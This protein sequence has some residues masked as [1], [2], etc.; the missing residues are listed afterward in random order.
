MV[1]QE[2]LDALANIS[3]PQRWKDPHPTY[4]LLRDQA[5]MLH[6]VDDDNWMLTRYDDCLQILRDPRWSSSPR[7]LRRQRPFEQQTMRER[8]GAEGVAIL[9]FMDPPDHTRLRKLVHRSFTPKAVDRWRVRIEEVVDDLLDQAVERGG[10]LELI[11]EFAYEVPVIV[12]C[13]LLGVPTSDH[14]LFG[15]WSSAAS[16][17]LDGDITPAEEQAGL[18]GAAG[19]IGYFNELIEERRALPGDD[20]LSAMIHATEDGDRLNED[21]L[22][23]MTLL[24]FIAGHETT[25]N[26]IGNGTLAL[27]RHRDQLERL[28]ADPT[29]VGSAVEEILRFDGPVHV[30]G[31]IPTEDLEVA[32]HVFEKGEQVVTLLA[33][34][35]RDPARFAEP[36]R[37]DIGRSDN[38]HLTFSMGIHHCLGASL[39]R[40][41]GQ[42]ALGRLVARFPDVELHTTDPEYREHFVLR[43]LRELRL[44]LGVG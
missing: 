7:H 8:S 6:N 38:Q 12:I 36:D 44:G 15:D 42:I 16:R 17:L 30:T 23:M 41:E 10:D 14:H 39:A 37:F 3:D 18:L 20:L 24:L 40:L 33:A 28:R 35:N 32:G 13:E 26:L 19:L 11:S 43:G 22:R 29:L 1:D 27:L 5:P 21:E 2:V 25:M 4:H 34:A 9:L 31:R